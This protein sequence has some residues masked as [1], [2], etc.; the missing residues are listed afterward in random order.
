MAKGKKEVE[1]RNTKTEGEM[2]A[3]ERDYQRACSFGES[4]WYTTVI[5]TA[6]QKGV[7]LGTDNI[8]GVESDSDDS[9]ITE[10]VENCASEAIVEARKSLTD[11]Q[12]WEAK[13]A[14]KGLYRKLLL[15]RQAGL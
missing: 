12:D 8:G 9:F 4:W 2:S 7:E 6:F 13:T 15:K 5:V 14:I 3:V 10:M 1:K 11:L